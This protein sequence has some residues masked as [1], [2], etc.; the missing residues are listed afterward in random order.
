MLR[1]VLDHLEA[2]VI[3]DDLNSRQD[4]KLIISNLDLHEIF[5]RG[6]V[7]AMGGD[8]KLAQTKVH[9]VALRDIP[10]IRQAVN[11]IPSI[12]GSRSFPLLERG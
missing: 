10:P 5:L 12:Q 2:F 3:T 8:A 11:I 4:N 9:Q 6:V 1:L 7:G